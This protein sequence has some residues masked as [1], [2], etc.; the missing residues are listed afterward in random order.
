MQTKDLLHWK[1]SHLQHFE[2]C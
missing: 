2:H 1:K